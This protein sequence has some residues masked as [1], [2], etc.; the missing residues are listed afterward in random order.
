MKNTKI[1]ITKALSLG[2]LFLFSLSQVFAQTKT[3]TGK[4]TDSKDGSPIVGATVQ[5]KGSKNG[6]STGA[7]GSFS[8]TVAAN[9]TTL[10]VTSVGFDRQE[11]SV[12]SSSTAAISLVASNSNLNEVVVVGYGTVRKKDLTGAIASVQAKDF[13]QGNIASPDQLLQNKVPGLEITQNSGQP[14]AATTIKIRGN[15]SIR[16]SQSPLY[17]VDGVPLDGGS[18]RPGIGT[19]F[20]GTPSSNPLLYINPNDIQSIDVLKDA[21]AA[22]I[23]GSRGANGVVVITLKKGTAGPMKMDVNVSYSLNAGFMRR[24]KVLDAGQFRSALTKYGASSTLDGGANTDALKEITQN[25]LSQNYNVAFSGGNENGK[26]RAS[27]LGS[28]N[29]GFLKKT[30]LDKYLGTFS[31]DY[32]FLDKKLSLNFYLIAGNVTENATSVANNSG[33]QGNLIVSALAWNPTQALT[34]SDGTYNYP[35]NGTGNP[36]AFNDAYNDVSSTASYL[37]GISGAYKITAQSGVQTFI[38]YQPFV[39][40]DRL[41]DVDGWIPGLN[42]LSGQGNAIIAH[43]KLTSQNI[44]HT[45]NYK[46]QLA[47]NLS[48]DALAGFEYYKSSYSTDNIFGRGFNTNLDFNNRIGVKY[49]SIF[50]NAQTVT[51]LFTFTNP[52]TEIQSVFARLNFNYNDQF[53]LTGTIRDDGSS[54]FG[55]NKKHGIFPSVSW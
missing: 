24:Y 29:Q 25:K 12:A 18:A 38:W 13:N 27:L 35:A 55:S 16:A 33:S 51:P 45:L 1:F 17:V 41:V 46:A 47:K 30:N 42:N 54:K 5:P 19:S 11:I 39:P 37:G 10:V 34:K 31:G 7:D 6:T 8:I 36:L 9:T 20:G 32:K 14:G 53:Y 3:I 44:T 28:T 49:T 21:S 22:A 50:Q 26:F 40:A 23:F 15:T 48:L 52:T 4:V 43:G 2:F